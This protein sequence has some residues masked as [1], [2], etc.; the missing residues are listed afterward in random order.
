MAPTIRVV[1]AKPTG[2]GSFMLGSKRQPTA[3]TSSEK[4]SPSK[5]RSAS[6]KP[7]NS[8][9]QG[10]KKNQAPLKYEPKFAASIE[11]R[12]IAAIAADE[13][14]NVV[15]TAQGPANTDATDDEPLRHLR[16]Q[17]RQVAAK[18]HKRQATF[19]SSIPGIGLPIF[20]INKAGKER[21]AMPKQIG[22]EYYTNADWEAEQARRRQRENARKSATTGARPSGIRKEKR[23]RTIFDAKPTPKAQR[24]KV[25]QSI[26]KD[27]NLVASYKS[28]QKP[29]PKP[30]NDDAPTWVWQLAS[31]TPEQRFLGIRKRFAKERDVPLGSATQENPAFHEWVD[32]MTPRVRSL[33]FEGIDM[34]KYTFEI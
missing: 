14:C 20:G 32:N 18:Q 13:T 8:R 10:V 26:K 9:P 24:N 7:D 21:A 27:V 25:L 22:E 11:T 28:H 23:P 30:A 17:L 15:E 4:T 16:K 34:S 5:R 31:T 1:Q 33:V 3:S 12:S 6:P 29:Q 19:I 2:F